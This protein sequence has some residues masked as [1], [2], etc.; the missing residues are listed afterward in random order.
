[1]NIINARPQLHTWRM[2]IHIDYVCVTQHFITHTFFSYVII[3]NIH[4]C[5][6]V[7]YEIKLYYCCRRT[8]MEITF[9]DFDDKGTTP[10][11]ASRVHYKVVETTS[12]NY[13]LKTS[14]Q[15]SSQPITVSVKWKHRFRILTG[16]KKETIGSRQ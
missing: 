6:V 16:M 5:P 14:P 9:Y 3:E 15:C 2:H 12:E 1:M 4:S 11:H 8:K 10:S 13:S 7:V